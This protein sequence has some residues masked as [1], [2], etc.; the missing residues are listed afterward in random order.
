[1]ALP[2]RTHEVG[3]AAVNPTVI[4]EDVMT[5]GNVS[6]KQNIAA[7]SQRR[8]WLRYAVMIAAVFTTVLAL[9]TVAPAQSVAIFLFGTLHS[10]S[11]TDGSVPTGSLIQASDG[12]FY[13]MT[14]GG[15]A[16][17]RGTVFVSFDFA[18]VQQTIVNLRLQNTQLEGQVSTL[19]SE[20]AELQTQLDQLNGNLSAGLI[21]VQNDFRTVF[22]DPD[23]AL[24]GSTPVGQLQNL[25]QAILNMTRGEKNPIYQGLRIK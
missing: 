13:G 23:F 20:K 17:G 18:T 16:N 8:R 22:K 24:P 1:M 7:Y 14:M 10:F 9:A 25:I 5:S 6:R 2:R 12:L 15:G 21:S 19:T 4:K 11:G 3:D